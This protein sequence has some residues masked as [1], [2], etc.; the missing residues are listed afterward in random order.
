MEDKQ[1]WKPALPSVPDTHSPYWYEFWRN[2]RFQTVLLC[3]CFLF[4]MSII[5]ALVPVMWIWTEYYTKEQEKERNE[6][7]RRR[8]REGLK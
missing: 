8:I 6:E 7:L 4:L 2:E 1:D 3:G 5:M